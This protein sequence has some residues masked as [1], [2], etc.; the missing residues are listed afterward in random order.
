MFLAIMMVLWRQR[1]NGNAHRREP[2][3][4]TGMVM[5]PNKQ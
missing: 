2:V 1:T 4:P 3:P 5:T